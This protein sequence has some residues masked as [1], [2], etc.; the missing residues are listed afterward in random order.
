[1]QSQRAGTHLTGIPNLGIETT[2]T[3][4]QMVGT[5][6]ECQLVVLAVQGEL[7]FAD[8]VTPTS[9]Q[10]G[11]VGLFTAHELLDA[12]MTLDDVTYFTVLV[13]Y[14][15]GTDSTSIIRD[16][17]FVTQTVLQDVQIGFLTIDR[18]LKVLAFQPTQRRCFCS[19]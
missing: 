9:N 1:M 11:Q 3:S 18:G 2:V 16:G 19:V 8:A 10:S 15:N 6:V 7:S 12:A 5:V 13:G 17:Y 14:H 4:M